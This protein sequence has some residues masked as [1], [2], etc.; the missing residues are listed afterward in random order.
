[1]PEQEK[2]NRELAVNLAMFLIDWR[3]QLHS[4]AGTA[5]PTTNVDLKIATA[6]GKLREMWFTA[7]MPKASKTKTEEVFNMAKQLGGRI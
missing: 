3:L 6:M 5:N 2:T 7:F 1:M 4:L